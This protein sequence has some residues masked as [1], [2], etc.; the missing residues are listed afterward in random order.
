MAHTIPERAMKPPSLSERDTDDLFAPESE[1]A[2]FQD[3]DPL[4]SSDSV[5]VAIQPFDQ[6]STAMCD[7]TQSSLDLF[8]DS[9]TSLDARDLANEIPGFQDFIAP[10]NKLQDSTCSAPNTPKSGNSNSNSGGPNPPNGGNQQGSDLAPLLNSE[11]IKTKLRDDGSCYLGFAGPGYSIALCCNGM[12]EGINV[13][14]CDRR[15]FFFFFFFFKKKTPDLPVIL[16]ATYHIR[17]TDTI[18]AKI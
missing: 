7:G 18:L 11:R 1:D 12:R 15:E 3:P 14:G 4:Y 10:L 16:P 17:I 8:L 5:N 6:A 13:H 9:P 2:L